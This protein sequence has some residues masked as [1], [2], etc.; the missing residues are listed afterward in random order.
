MTIFYSAETMGSGKT[1]FATHYA[2]SFNEQNPNAKIYANYKIKL[3]KIRKGKKLIENPNFIFTKYLVLP[4][5]E[6]TKSERSLIIVDDCKVLRNLN[7]FIEIISSM[8]RKVGIDIIIT[9]QYYTMIKKELRELADYEVKVNYIVEKDILEVILI[10][11]NN[12]N[13]CFTVH[14]IVKIIGDLYD[15]NEIVNI[16]NERKINQELLRFCENLE[17]L[18]SNLSLFYKDKRTYSKN[19]KN[20]SIEKGLI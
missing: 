14:D 8:S 15:T 19:L 2:L 5:S 13:H 3:P 7:Y 12:N 9:G 11:L 16:P 10:D 6:I 17:D 20:L 4:L 1:I 18:E